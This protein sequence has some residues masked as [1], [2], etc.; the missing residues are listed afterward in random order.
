ML[1]ETIVGVI[2]LFIIVATAHDLVDVSGKVGA[3]ILEDAK[4]LLPTRVLLFVLLLLTVIAG[5]ILI[6]KIRGQNI[7]IKETFVTWR[8]FLF[9]YSDSGHYW[10]R[11]WLL[12]L[13]LPLLYA[14]VAEIIVK[15]ILKNV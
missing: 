13:I 14:A 7:E 2:I 11:H 5:E 4:V 10:Q 8:E 3:S 15:Q 6:K 1:S 9:D 12:K